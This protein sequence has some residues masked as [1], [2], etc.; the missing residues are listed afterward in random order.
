MSLDNAAMTIFGD[1]ISGNCLKVKWV[2]ERLGLAYDW[3]ETSVLKAE[4]RTPEFL[5]MNPAGQVPVVRFADNGP[6]AQSNAIILHL[7]QNSDLIPADP[8]ERALMYQWLFWEQ[9]SHEPAI[10]VLR[11][12][13]F[14]LKKNDS[15]I[16]PALVAKCLKVLSLMNGHL[17]SHDYF[18]GKKLSLADIAL[19][20]YTRFAHQADLD[21]A[22]YPYVSAWV[23]RVERD[24]KLESLI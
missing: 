1:S 9:Y 11:F 20:A 17:A 8:F 19:V 22:L 5:A 6:L 7:A 18:V 15:E 23:G 4:T 13:K 2:A 21:L 3:V 10:A 12:Q 24:L 16:D 14:Y